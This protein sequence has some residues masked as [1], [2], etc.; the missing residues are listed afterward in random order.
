[1][2]VLMY[3][4]ENH[5]MHRD[6]KGSNILL[7]R[8]GEVKLVDFGLS[9]FLKN[10]LDKRGTYIGS[11]C[12]MAPEMI[13]NAFRGGDKTYDSR[14]DVWA[15]GITSI[16][17]GDGKAPFLDIHPTRALFQIVRNPPPKLYRPANWSQIYND[18]ITECLEK[19]PEH[20]PFIMELI[21]HP[22]LTSLPENDF[23]LSQELKL[24]INDFANKGQLC[25]KTEFTVKNGFLKTGLSPKMELMHQEDL[26]AIEKLNEET[27]TEELHQR[28]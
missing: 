9:R 7:T 4:H 16:E 1:K 28:L 11:P 19:N 23:H 22:F 15:L 14:I 6:V 5:V 12:W 13:T 2:L 24:L 27:I 25:R 8:D 17:L 18:F 3:L 21:E 10:T 26:A 20:R